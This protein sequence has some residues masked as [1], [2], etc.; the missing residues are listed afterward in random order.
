MSPSEAESR[1]SA[2]GREH[3]TRLSVP[4]SNTPTPLAALDGTIVET[5]DAKDGALIIPTDLLA[6]LMWIVGRWQSAHPNERDGNRH[7]TPT[8]RD[9][10][11][12]LAKV[13]P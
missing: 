5:A 9:L 11:L 10:L 2:R 12:W 13:M 1:N 6:D 4:E 3:I 8:V 7:R